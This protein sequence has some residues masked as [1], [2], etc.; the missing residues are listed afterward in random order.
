MGEILDV[1][2]LE[3]QNRPPGAIT[4]GRPDPRAHA[5]WKISAVLGLV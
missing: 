5:L 3:V 1:E 2:V 4:E